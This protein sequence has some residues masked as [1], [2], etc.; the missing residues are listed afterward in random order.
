MRLDEIAERLGRSQ[1]ALKQ[2][3]FRVRR[4]LRRCIELNLRSPDG[5][6]ASTGAVP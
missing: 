2:V 3:L 1:G 5:L 6:D 4:A